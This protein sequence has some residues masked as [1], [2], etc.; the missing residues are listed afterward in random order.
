MKL[1]DGLRKGLTRRA[2]PHG[3]A[4]RTMARITAD[5]RGH[6]RWS[7]HTAVRRL[8][9][10]AVLVVV[11]SGVTVREIERRRAAEGERARRDVMTA[12]HIASDKVREAQREIRQ[13]GSA[14]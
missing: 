4:E 2:A 3:F 10:A 13:I 7:G 9:A 12:L 11:L 5:E 1:D 14:D 8:A 6:H